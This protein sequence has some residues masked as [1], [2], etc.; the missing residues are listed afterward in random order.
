MGWMVLL[1]RGVL[2][3]LDRQSERSVLQALP[4]L[5]RLLLDPHRE[6][7]GRAVV[8]GPARRYGRAIFLGLIFG[9]LAWWA[10]VVLLML[11]HNGAPAARPASSFLL[12]LLVL[13]PAASIYVML[14]WVRGGE[15]TLR[16]NEVELSY[17]GTVVV[18][19][20][21][22]FHTAGQPFNPDP[23]RIVLPVVAAAVPLVQARRD[24]DVVAEGLRVN[25]PQLW[26]RSPGEM[27][28]RALYEVN[29]LELGKVLLHLGR[30]L[31]T[32]AV[33][34]T[35]ALDFPVTETAEPGPAR[36]DRGGWLTVSLTR[37]T[38]PPACCQC[39][40]AT[41]GRQKFLAAEAFFDLSRLAHPTRSASVPVWVPVCYACQTANN[42]KLNRAILNGLGAGVV[43]I[44]VAAFALLLWPA[45][46]LL[47]L[48]FALSVV[49]G[50]LL[51][52]LVF[53]QLGKERVMPVEVGSY[54]PRRGTVAIR[55]RRQEYSEE[56][57]KAI[58]EGQ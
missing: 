20:W 25:T 36:A 54:S 57:L 23:D 12:V 9:F 4:D 35:P 37:L 17:R 45:N 21:A 30:I 43:L 31:G 19:P 28:L 24:G 50:P 48:V 56:L 10:A 46:L 53:Y 52:T 49:L 1:V 26:F 27:A 47:V 42:Q 15:V 18:C 13:F 38:F 39:G 41:R 6:L 22:L 55:F 40:A 16:E 2:V 32:A 58:N 11:A 51:G 5:D 3:W 44:F 33:G 7:Q 29:A 14:R 8:I 34:T